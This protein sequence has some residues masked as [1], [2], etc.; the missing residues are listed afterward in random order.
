MRFSTRLE[1]AVASDAKEW[2]S[3]CPEWASSSSSSINQC[4]LKINWVSFVHIN[5]FPFSQF[6][7]LC[8]RFCYFFRFFFSSA[9]L[10][11]HTYFAVI[12][13]W[14]HFD[15]SHKNWENI[16]VRWLTEKQ[17]FFCIKWEINGTENVLEKMTGNSVDGEHTKKNYSI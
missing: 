10:L 15:D 9:V 13:R 3:S 12:S 8:S 2:I 14:R 6:W 5:L 11:Q 1:V 4:Q 16:F 7:S 17:S